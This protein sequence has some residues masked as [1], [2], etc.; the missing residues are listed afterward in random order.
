MM[1]LNQPPNQPR[2]RWPCLWRGE[3]GEVCKKWAQRQRLCRRHIIQRDRQR[4]RIINNDAPAPVGNNADNNN[5]QVQLIDGE[6]VENVGNP[7]NNNA[8]DPPHVVDEQ[9]NNAAAHNH[10]I[11]DN[12]DQGNNVDTAPVRNTANSTDNNEQ[13]N[14]ADNN[15]RCEVADGRLIDAVVGN[16]TTFTINYLNNELVKRDER[17][18]ELEAKVGDLE[19][20]MTVLSDRNGGR[21][22]CTSIGSGGSSR[23]SLLS[24][25]S[26]GGGLDFVA[27]G[28]H[29]GDEKVGDAEEEGGNGDHKRNARKR[30]HASKDKEG[31]RD[32]EEDEKSNGDKKP[33]ARKKQ[34]ARNGD[35]STDANGSQNPY[36]RDFPTSKR[37]NVSNSE[38]RSDGAHA[39]LLNSDVICYSNAIFQCI[40]CCADLGLCEEFLRSQPS[41]EHQHFKL[42][43]EFKS[44]ISSIL[45]NG[46]DTIDPSKFIGLYRERYTNVDANEGKWHGNFIKQ[47]IYIFKCIFD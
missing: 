24:G 10:N 31:K 38:R 17:I 40:A 46:M 29:G 2:P 37:S 5:D 7:A 47:C 13:L 39:G 33:R 19:Q 11:A 6:N 30:K 22:Q 21:W 28:R 45:R 44:L 18:K 35:Q 3:N 16:E 1:D 43:Y 8:N 23:F 4:A 12:N 27:Q 36:Y 20:K 42:Y 14:D 9:T 26:L 41:E 15:D 34:C 32:N 25:T